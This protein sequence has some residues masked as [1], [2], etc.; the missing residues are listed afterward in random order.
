MPAQRVAR[1]GRHYGDVSNF[2]EVFRYIRSDKVGL[3]AV[4]LRYDQDGRLARVHRLPRAQEP[5]LANRR[6]NRLAGDP[7][8]PFARIG[9]SHSPGQI[10]SDGFLHPSVDRRQRITNHLRPTALNEVDGPGPILCTRLEANAKRKA[11]ST[12]KTAA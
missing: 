6:R 12:E 1:V 2:R 10:E 3:W 9:H 5:G 8:W 4:V 11:R 7:R